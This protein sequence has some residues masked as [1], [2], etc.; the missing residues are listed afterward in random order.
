MV[1][2]YGLF[3]TKQLLS[4]RF[5]SPGLDFRD[6]RLDGLKWSTLYIMIDRYIFLYFIFFSRLLFHFLF[7]FYG[8]VLT[9]IGGGMPTIFCIYRLPKSATKI[10]TNLNVNF[11]PHS[12]S[13]ISR[14]W[15]SDKSQVCSKRA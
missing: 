14:C 10:R 6:I 15:H 12:T 7:I 1:P 2:S 9:K 4:E 11:S 8:T 5:F 3:E 13:A